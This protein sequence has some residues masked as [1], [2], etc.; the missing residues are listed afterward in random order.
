VAYADVPFT[1]VDL[2]VDFSEEPIAE[3]RRMWTMWEPMVDSYI[4]RCMDPEN[5]LAA[6]AIEG[7]PTR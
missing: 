7:H 3:L 1:P 5:S 2:R 4:Q 6:A